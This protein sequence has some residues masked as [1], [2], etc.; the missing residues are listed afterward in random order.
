MSLARVLT[1]VAGVTLAAAASAVPAQAAP[2]AAPNDMQPMIIDGE[3][4]TDAPWAVRQFN[5]GQ[6]ACSA[7]AIAPE[8]VLTAQHCVEGAGDA[9]SFHVGS[10]NQHEGEEFK[11][12]AGGVHIHDSVD[13]AL[14]NVDR[15]MDVEFAPLGTTGDVNNGDT[16][17]VY[18]WGATCTDQPEAQCQADN[19]KVAD[20][21]VTDIACTDYR[22]GTAVCADRINGITA[23]GDS[24]GPM[25]SNGKQ[26]GVASTSDRATSTA[27]NNITEYRDWIKEVAGV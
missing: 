4:A 15:P 2:A 18:G 26:V 12:K 17:Q 19:L 3:E 6:E 11:A 27:Y 23:G 8:W 7:T 10:L 1:G 9:V 16:V 22:G 24:G 25:F 14:V 21:K 13:L 20:V 5:D